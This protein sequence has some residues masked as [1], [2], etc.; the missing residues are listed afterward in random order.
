[1]RDNSPTKVQMRQS[2]HVYSY[3]VMC[4]TVIFLDLH[5][6]R[7]VIARGNFIK[8]TFLVCYPSNKKNIQGKLYKQ[9]KMFAM[10]YENL[11]GTKII[12]YN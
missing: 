3:Y 6:A 11:Q 1:M 4:K 10:N 2:R 9:N 12:F 5:Y 8:T 7:T